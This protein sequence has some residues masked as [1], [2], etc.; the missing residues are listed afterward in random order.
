MLVDPDDPSPDSFRTEPL[1]SIFMNTKHQLSAGT[2][3][4][5]LIG[6]LIALSG[7]A[8]AQRQSNTTGQPIQP[9][10]RTPHFQSLQLKASMVDVNALTNA[11]GMNRAQLDQLPDRMVLVLDGPMTPAMRTR[12]ASTGAKL[13]DYLPDH[14]YVVDLSK[15]RVA[16]LRALPFVTH[17]VKFDDAWKVDP[18]LGQRVPVSASRKLIAAQNKVAA[19]VYLFAG[20]Q[21]KDAIKQISTQSSVEIVRHELTDDRF[22]LQVIGS[23]DEIRSLSKIN[24]V[25]WIESAPEITLRNST[26]RWVVQSNQTN[27][28]PIYEAGLHGENQLIAVIDGEV[29]VDHCAFADPEGD[30]FGPDHRKIQAFNAQSFFPS[31]HGT[32]VAGTALGDNGF[33]DENRGIAYKS[34]MI[35][36]TEP[37]FTFSAFTIKLNTHY[38]QGASIHA[39]SWGDDFTTAYSGLARAVDTFSYNNDDN[40]VI[41]AAT[42][43]DE[44]KSPENA[45]NCLAVG[46]S[47]DAGNQGSFCSGGIGPTDDGRRKPEL[48]APGCDIESARSFTEC[49]TIGFTGTSMAAPAIAG[50]A[51]LA[52]QY[53]EEGFYPS[54]LAESEDGFVPSGTLLK[55]ILLNSAVDM[56]GITGFPSEQEGWGRVL[57]D[58]G[59]YLDGDT[60]KLVIRDVRNASDDALNTEDMFDMRF[61][62]DSN[63][64]PLKVTLVWHDAPAAP[65]AAFAP[66]NNLD[67]EVINPSGGILV[68]NSITNGVSQFGGSPDSINNVEMVMLPTPVTGEYTIRVKGTAVNA[69]QQGYAIVM[70]GDITELPPGGCNGADMAEPFGTFDFFDVS[71]FLDAFGAQN[72]AADIDGNELFD[73]FD[74]SAFLD[75][76]ANGCPGGKGSS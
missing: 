13:G 68:G 56:T 55:A 44:L 28:F 27:H 8:L 48:F 15:A 24:A 57:L 64:E 41:F 29:D 45:K 18:E 66:V 62:V 37:Q 60:R 59:L 58:N 39:N 11:K 25:Q 21:I 12:I 17:M 4:P 33:D 71:A 70:T 34:R 14:A 36:D 38:A 72:P 5:V 26:S 20:E 67:L 69:G 1:W 47:Q 23:P 3:T 74:V 49:S 2:R 42:N 51:A 32:H 76:F 46:A 65:N 16:T 54:G 22:L 50:T 31:S 19:H 61:T 30:P 53:F 73:F 35:F 9:Q 52:R 43:R 63:S 75:L 10:Q 40:L 7:S 6:M